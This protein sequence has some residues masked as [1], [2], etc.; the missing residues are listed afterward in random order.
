MS[1]KVH[2]KSDIGQRSNNEDSYWAFQYKGVSEQGTAVEGAIIAVCDGMGGLSGGEVASSKTIQTLRQ[3]I[4][5]N[6]DFS[7]EGIVNAIKKANEDLYNLGVQQAEEYQRDNPDKPL[8]AKKRMLG[9]TCTL[10][11]L[12]GTWYRL[13][14]VGDSRC[15]HIYTDNTYSALT[16]DHTAFEKYKHDIKRVDANTFLLHGKKHTP[17]QIGKL[18]SSLTNSVGTKPDITVDVQSGEFQ[19][20]DMFL[21]SSDG[22]WHELIS[23]RTSIYR[24]WV[25]LIK[26][27]TDKAI[28]QLMERFK[29]NGEKDNLT[30]TVVKAL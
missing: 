10:L 5:D 30:V 6:K 29:A 24:E 19:P 22:F 4:V 26:Q 18:A 25:P 16:V 1:F 9:T 28:V 2:Y 14:H 15:Y 12:E 27:D 8:S 13:F 20:G 3:T 7:T 23:T 11:A 17:R 21:I